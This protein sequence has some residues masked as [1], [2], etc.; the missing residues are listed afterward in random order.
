MEFFEAIF[1]SDP[2]ITGLKKGGYQVEINE[3]GFSNKE[4]YLK[5]KSFF[6][7]LKYWEREDFIPHFEVNIESAVLVKEA[8]LT[9][10]LHFAPHMFGCPFIISQRVRDVFETFN[11]PVHFYYPVQLLRNNETLNSYCL[12]YLPYLGFDYVD[13]KNSLFYTGYG[14]LNNTKIVRINSLNEFLDFS[15]DEILRVKELA[16]NEKFNKP[17]DLF[18]SKLGGLFVS[19]RLKQA[20]THNGLLGLNFLDSVKVKLA[21]ASL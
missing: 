7:S 19:E 1:N 9:D 16:F 2:K 5:I 11:L 15:G 8:K 3:K 12:F 21:K 6:M 20:I 17:L 14:L 4:N 13:Y 10:F 18:N